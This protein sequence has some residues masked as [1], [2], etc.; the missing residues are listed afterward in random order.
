[1]I[2]D[3][4][5]PDMSGL[6]VYAL[7]R[8]I[9][10]RLPVIVITAHGTTDTA[11][12]AMKLGA[13]EYLLKPLDLGQLKLRRGGGHPYQQN[14]PDAGDVWTKRPGVAAGRRPTRRQFATH[15]GD[16]QVH[17][18]H[19]PARLTVLVLGESGTGKELVARAIYQ[20]SRRSQARSWRS[21]APPSRKRW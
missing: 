1:M 20:H 10:A 15:A 7:I 4:R 19:C 14:Q 8:Q 16:L 21:T 5:L 6:V 3:L 2:L 17:R 18:P 9:D 13:F 12:E 11:I